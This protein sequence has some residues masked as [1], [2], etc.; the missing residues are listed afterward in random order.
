[1]RFITATEIQR[2]YPQYS[3]YAINQKIRK[4][5]KKRKDLNIEEITETYTT[6]K[7]G[8]QKRS[9]TNYKLSSKAYSILQ[10]NYLRN[11]E[12]QSTNEKAIETLATFAATVKDE[13]TRKVLE[14]IPALL[15]QRVAQIKQEL[16][17]E[18]QPQVEKNI[19]RLTDLANA[20]SAIHGVNEQDSEVQK[21]TAIL[22][23]VEKIQFIESKHS[24]LATLIQDIFTERVPA[25]RY[26][27]AW[28]VVNEP[29]FN[30]SPGKNLPMF[31]AIWKMYTSNKIDW[32]GEVIK[33]GYGRD[34]DDTV[35]DRIYLWY[36]EWE[37]RLRIIHDDRATLYLSYE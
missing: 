6:G 23:R 20:W 7:N 4:L 32:Q 22:S 34:K 15:E 33:G 35:I 36:K 8:K 16:A 9:R 11:K 17:A 25:V 21:V 24:E 18:L 10:V 3:Q 19:Q 14:M 31:G 29:R 37:R 13:Q 27:T 12:A 5:K 28:R 30:D 26:L 2:R 1:M